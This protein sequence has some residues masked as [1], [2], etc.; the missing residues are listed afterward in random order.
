MIKYHGMKKNTYFSVSTPV[1]VTFLLELFAIE[2]FEKFEAVFFVRTFL[3]PQSPT[4]LAPPLL[5][6]IANTSDT[7]PASTHAS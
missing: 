1:T 3:T 2:R 4:N 5:A 7:L 6:T